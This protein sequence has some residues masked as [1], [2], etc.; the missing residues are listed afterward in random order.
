M[1]Y[2]FGFLLVSSSPIWVPLVALAYAIGR[3][4]FSLLFLFAVLTA[5]AISLGAVGFLLWWIGPAGP[6][7]NDRP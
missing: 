5:E 1:L 3:K 2:I 6:G 4:K 7:M